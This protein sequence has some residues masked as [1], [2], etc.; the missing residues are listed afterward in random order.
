MMF[1]ENHINH[2]KGKAGMLMALLFFMIYAGDCYSQKNLSTGNLPPLLT[3]HHW[4]KTAFSPKVLL[5]QMRYEQR[6]TEQLLQEKK[7]R[8]AK[9]V[10]KEA[11]IIRKVMKNDFEENFSFCPVYYFM[12][13]NAELIKKQVFEN[14]LFTADG[15]P[16]QG[17]VLQPGDTDYFIVYYGYPE[18]QMNLDATGDEEYNGINNGEAMGK[19]LIFL[20]YNYRQVDF[21]YRFAYMDIFQRP[22]TRYFYK[23]QDYDME[24]YPFAAQ[25][26]KDLNEKING[27]FIERKKMPRRY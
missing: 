1:S 25:Y 22:D 8:E 20:N 24:Y 18:E 23:S 2:S 17:N 3:K 16:M 15:I 6:K 4:R 9:K 14:V 10:M 12:D 26:Q 11:S 13:T 7:T 27:I 19:G 21:Y 5:V